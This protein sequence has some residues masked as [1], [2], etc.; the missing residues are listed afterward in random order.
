MDVQLRMVNA[1]HEE[2]GYLVSSSD[3]FGILLGCNWY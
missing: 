2:D 3:S 1:D